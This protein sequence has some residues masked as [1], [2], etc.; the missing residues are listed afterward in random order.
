M[1]VVFLFLAF[2]SFYFCPIIA[3]RYDLTELTPKGN[4]VYVMV[5]NWSDATYGSSFVSCLGEEQLWRIKKNPAEADFILQITAWYRPQALG[6]VCDVYAVIL[7]KNGSFLWRSDIYVGHP[8]GFNGYDY[9]MASINKIINEGLNKDLKLECKKGKHF[10]LDYTGETKVPSSEYQQSEEYFFEGISYLEEYDTTT[11]LSLFDKSI[12]LN[13]YNSIV[14]KYKAIALYN[15]K[16][17]KSARDIICKAMEYDPLSP[18]NDSIYL[19]IMLEKNDKYMKQMNLVSTISNTILQF[20]T[21]FAQSQTNTNSFSQSVRASSANDKSNSRLKKV[22]C[23]NCHG[24]GIN[25]SPTHSVSFAGSGEEYCKICCKIV[26]SGHG[27]HGDCPSCMGKGCI[28]KI[29]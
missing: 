1:K 7:D 26:S 22:I 4:N 17:Y 19:S 11:A 15:Q 5:N 6:I 13:P 21:T 29:Q 24:T 9:K 16:K 18:L 12:K 25:P 27:Y 3:Q 20:S 10:V 23:S 2:L 28:M 8:T 14:Y